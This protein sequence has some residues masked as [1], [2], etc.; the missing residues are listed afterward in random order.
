MSAE[1][2]PIYPQFFLAPG[3]GK[4]YVVCV[5]IFI[6]WPGLSRDLQH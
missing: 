1:D 6:G 4:V 2:Y 3:H 5:L